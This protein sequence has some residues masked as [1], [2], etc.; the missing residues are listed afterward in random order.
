MDKGNLDCRIGIDNQASA[1]I[2][3][4]I[5]DFRGSVERVDRSVTG[6]GRKNVTEV[7]IA[8]IVWKW[9]DSDKDAKNIDVSSNHLLLNSSMK[10]LLLR[11]ST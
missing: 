9:S 11:S 4:Y 6:L 5:V 1:C 8:T 3:A 10:G 2:S 7:N